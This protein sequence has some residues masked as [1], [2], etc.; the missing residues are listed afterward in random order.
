MAKMLDDLDLRTRLLDQ[1]RAGHGRYEACK[2]VGISPVTFRKYCQ[3]NDEFAREV[4]AAVDASIEP[5]TKMLRDKAINEEHVDAAKAYLNHTEKQRPTTVRHEHEHTHSLDDAARGQIESIVELQ[6]R[7]ALRAQ[8]A[9]L[10]EGDIEDAVLED[11]DGSSS[12]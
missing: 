1:I 2:I 4:E 9:E 3:H 6:E 7:L 8:Y 11:E 12:V 5:V 10:P